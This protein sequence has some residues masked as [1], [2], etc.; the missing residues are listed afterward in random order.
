MKS[1]RFYSDAIKF[2][3]IANGPVSMIVNPTGVWPN[4][5]TCDYYWDLVEGEYYELAS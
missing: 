5:F 4:R 2:A 3:F 1:F